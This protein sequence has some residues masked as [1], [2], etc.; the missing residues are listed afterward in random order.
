MV[1]E[2]LEG[3]RHLESLA[4]VGHEATRRTGP[5]QVRQFCR[6]GHGKEVGIFS[7]IFEL[8]SFGDSDPRGEGPDHQI[9]PPA[10]PRQAH[11]GGRLVV[12]ARGKGG[13]MPESL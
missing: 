1:L 8:H 4:A 2:R 6:F 10:R 13:K 3:P 7:Q 9:D 11:C 12:Q 5:D